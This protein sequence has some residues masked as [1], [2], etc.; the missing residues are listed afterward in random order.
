VQLTW[1]LDWNFAKIYRTHCTIELAVSIIRLLSVVLH[2]CKLFDFLLK[3]SAVSVGLMHNC[4][5]QHELFSRQHETFDQ[6][7]SKFL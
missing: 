6:S 7:S 3:N 2:V 5:R 4:V 1:L